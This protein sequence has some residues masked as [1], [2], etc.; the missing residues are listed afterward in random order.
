VILSLL[1]V[2][3]RMLY[4]IQGADFVHI[5]VMEYKAPVLV[6][7]TLKRKH[8]ASKEILTYGDVRVLGHSLVSSSVV[9][10]CYATLERHFHQC[11][12]HSGALL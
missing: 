5:H 12:G 10:D 1:L 7:V 9:G 6:F 4:Q 3:G 11:S 8:P 2:A